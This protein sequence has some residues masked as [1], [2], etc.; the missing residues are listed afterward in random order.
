MLSHHA[1]LFLE[2][3]GVCLYQSATFK[4]MSLYEVNSSFPEL[5]LW[6]HFVL[7]CS[8]ITKLIKV[9]KNKEQ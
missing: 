6:L 8:N 7:W 4:L 1:Q 2:A 3:G 5:L 9:N